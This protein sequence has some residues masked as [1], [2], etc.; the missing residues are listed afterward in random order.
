VDPLRTV[1]GWL[2]T[3]SALYALE[4]I[5]ALHATCSMQGGAPLS[6]VLSAPRTTLSSAQHEQL[7]LVAILRSRV[8]AAC[9]SRA[10]RCASEVR[11]IFAIRCSGSGQRFGESCQSLA[12]TRPSWRSI[13][14]SVWNVRK[15][16]RGAAGSHKVLHPSHL[17]G[18]GLCTFMDGTT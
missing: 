16:Q 9:G 3:Q 10:L 4:G 8:F 1:L 5:G 18:C 12:W 15:R 13:P 17:M 14:V 6:Q 11:Q 2:I 7:L